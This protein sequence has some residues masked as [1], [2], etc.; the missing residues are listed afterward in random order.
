MAVLT[1]FGTVSNQQRHDVRCLRENLLS[2]AWCHYCLK[3][4]NT[5]LG[6]LLTKTTQTVLQ[7]CTRNKMLRNLKSTLEK[8]TETGARK[9]RN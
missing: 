1:V 4:V 9:R 6:R 8:Q 2:H 3:T 5:C 7:A